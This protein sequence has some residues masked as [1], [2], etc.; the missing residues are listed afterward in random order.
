MQFVKVA[1][2][3]NLRCLPPPSPQK[4]SKHAFIIKIIIIIIIIIIK[5]IIFRMTKKFGREK[6]TFDGKAARK[7]P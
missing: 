5:E 1:E 4:M 6:F 3:A 7:N 2:F